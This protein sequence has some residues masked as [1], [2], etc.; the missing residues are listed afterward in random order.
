MGVVNVTPDSFSDG[1][2]WLDAGAA[3]QHGRDLVAQGADLVD[4]GGESTRPG[5]ERVDVDEELRRVLPV[6]AALATEGHLVSVDTM[7][8]EVARQALDAGAVMVNDVSGGL[9]DEAMAGVVAASGAPFV[10]MHWRGHSATMN[11]L[12]QYDDVVTDVVR[13]L[14]GRIDALVDAG[15]APEQLVLDPGLG[16]AK[17]AEHNWAVLA[18][19]DELA[20]LG[21][22]LLVGAS[23]KRFLGSLLSEP[24]GEPRAVP[25]REAATVATTVIAA[26]AGSWCVRVHDVPGNADAVRVVQATRSGAPGMAVSAGRHR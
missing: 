9:A 12:A 11:A 19:L 8:A 22:P 7:R 20:V 10:V 13:E 25:E 16:F 18:R 3:V 2:L 24:D 15:V 14:G 4:V 6:V 17:Q 5:A 23:R 1:G 26:M 21:R